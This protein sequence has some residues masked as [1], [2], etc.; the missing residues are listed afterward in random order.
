MRLRPGVHGDR[1]LCGVLGVGTFALQVQLSQ[2][3][4]AGGREP[5]VQSAGDHDEKLIVASN[6]E[7]TRA[8]HPA[9]SLRQI[10]VNEHQD[11]IA[12]FERGLERLANKRKQRPS[13]LVRETVSS[14]HCLEECFGSHVAAGLP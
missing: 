11:P 5:V 6:L 12:G 8:A 14:A 4:N 3:E 2:P 1:I 7:L 10:A 9:G 13:T